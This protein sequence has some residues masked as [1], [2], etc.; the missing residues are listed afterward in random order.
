MPTALA[1]VDKI[2]GASVQLDLNDQS[3]LWLDEFDA[4]PPPLRRQ[5]ANSLLTDG[6]KL[7]AAAYDNR[8]LTISWALRDN[9]DNMAT[10][11]QAITRQLDQQDN[12]IR[13]SPQGATSPM[14]FRT[15]RSSVGDVQETFSKQGIRRASVSVL[16][17]PFG[18]GTR[19][20]L[21]AVTITADPATGSNRLSAALG[22]VIGDVDTPAYIYRAGVT[23]TGSTVL[24]GCEHG[25]APSSPP[26]VQA[27]SGTLGPDAS[28]VVDAAASSGNVLRISFAG[29]TVHQSRLTAFRIPANEP[30]MYRVF[31]RL[32]SSSSSAVFSVQIGEATATG[33]IIFGDLK[34]W[35]EPLT[36]NQWGLVDLGL[37]QFPPGSSLK[38]NGLS[39]S[40]LARDAISTARLLAGR[41][42]GSGTLDVDF[43]VAI[44]AYGQLNFSACSDAAGA[45]STTVWDGYADEMLIFNGT[46]SPW[47][48]PTFASGYQFARV[49]GMPML[50]P[51]VTNRLWY[52]N[53]LGNIITNPHVLTASTTLNVSYWP[54]YLY[55]R[56]AAT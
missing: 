31:A 41:V 16:A 28:V 6:G 37:F 42:S 49:G 53:D 9:V 1:F 27:E 7:T 12:L 51:N 24:L 33:N 14:F 11:L 17:E 5:V 39:G 48:S 35:T 56:P 4:P 47:S 43:I 32:R 2:D 15:L 45:S 30:G 20:D 18:Y 52:V 54:R 40:V 25:A 38:E 55:A 3:T 13:W 36:A 29:S 22:A 44:P 21:A 34:T 23:Q 46:G 10:K 26:A 19:Q 50:T 8:E